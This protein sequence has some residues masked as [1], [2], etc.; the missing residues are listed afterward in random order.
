MSLISLSSLIL[1]GL[2][3]KGC[4]FCLKLGM[5]KMTVAS[6]IFIFGVPLC[7]VYYRSF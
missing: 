4:K 1:K 3:E 6:I 5:F 2:P 7:C